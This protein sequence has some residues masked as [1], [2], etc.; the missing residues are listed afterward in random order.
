V[1]AQEKTAGLRAPADYKSAIW[2]IENLRYVRFEGST[3]V[4]GVLREGR[5]VGGRQKT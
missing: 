5:T 3:L 4:G 2:Q 1:A